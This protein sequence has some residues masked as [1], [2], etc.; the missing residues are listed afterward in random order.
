MKNLFLLLIILTLFS[1]NNSK[2]KIVFNNNSNTMVDS[3]V[4]SGNSKCN[5]LIIKKININSSY[6]EI[7][8]NCNEV[9]GDGSYIV[10]IY[11]KNKKTEKGFGYFTNGYMY[12]EK[13]VIDYNKNNVIITE[14]Y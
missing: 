4:I 5:P 12:F 11:S 7:L 9:N 6:T 14:Y 1:C 2:N 10:K 8:K 3:V 13:F